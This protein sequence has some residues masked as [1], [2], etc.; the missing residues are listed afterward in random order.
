MLS[1]NIPVYN[2]EVVDLVLQLLNQAEKLNV[3]YEIRVYDD[4][5]ESGFKQKNRVLSTYKNIFYNELKTNY[6]RAQIR[7]LMGADSNFKYLLFIDA[8]S[9]I[10]SSDYLNKFL[11]NISENTVLCGGTCYHKKAPAHDKLLRW[12]YGNAREAISATE[13]NSKKGFVITSNNF[14]IGKK[15]FE[16]VRFR[17]NLKNYGHEDTLLGYDLWVNNVKILHIDNP[18]L[19]TGLESSA[20][21]IEKSKV[22]L[23]SLHFITTNILPGNVEFKKQVYFLNR[24]SKISL[25]LFPAILRLLYR[26]LHKRIEKNLLGKNPRLFWFDFYKL[27]YYSTIK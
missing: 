16:A 21:F 20:V 22:A 3:S 10:V 5:S 18:V 12:V 1:I 9:E 17:D 26:L 11:T 15:L 7:N 23:E 14:L 8:D 19:H 24:Y 2:I 13:R 27:T 6:G 25:Y 4:G